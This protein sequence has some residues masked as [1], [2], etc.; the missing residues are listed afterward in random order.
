MLPIRPPQ[1]DAK[2]ELH[3]GHDPVAIA[4]A[5]ARLGQVQLKATHI[6]RC[7]GVRRSLQK[8]SETL[9]AGDVTALRVRAK[10]ARVRIVHHAL[11]QRAD[12]IR[13]HDDSC[14]G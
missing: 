9:A 12:R 1:C 5:H 7:G 11:T 4:D 3:T 8:C 2:Q 13:T 10:F 6:I 14:L